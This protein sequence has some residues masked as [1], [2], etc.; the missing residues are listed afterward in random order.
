MRRRSR[1]RANRPLGLR[2]GGGGGGAVVAAV[3]VV[4][5]CV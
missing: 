4:V 5:V 2:G 1:Q 3:V